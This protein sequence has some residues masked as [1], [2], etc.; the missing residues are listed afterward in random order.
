M[1]LDE[2][3][4]YNLLNLRVFKFYVS[5]NGK[6]VYTIIKKQL[7]YIVAPEDRLFHAMGKEEFTLYVQ[8]QIFNYTNQNA[9]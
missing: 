3:S 9:V 2:T 5:P 7:A 1:H 6:Y 8:N 4:I